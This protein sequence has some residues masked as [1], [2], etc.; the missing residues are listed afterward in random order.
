MSDFTITRQIAAP[1]TT[2]WGVLDDFGAIA[3][4][5]E[6][7]KRSYL[8]TEAPVGLGTT[9]HCDFV[10]MGGVNERITAHVPNERITVHLYEI[11]KMPVSDAVAERVDAVAAA[12]GKAGAKVSDRAR[13]SFTAQQSHVTY[14]NL[15]M[16]LLQA[17]VPEPMFQQM[18][19][20]ADAFAPGQQ[21]GEHHHRRADDAEN[22]PGQTA[23]GGTVRLGTGVEPVTDTANNQCQCRPDR[24]GSM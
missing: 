8:T 1:V 22:E 7:V 17:G 19:A 4:W 24:P 9:R 14:I 3:D 12:L 6:G 15:L 21:P 5:S 13:P 2:V 10:P 16:P 23:S 11:F 20:R 18:V